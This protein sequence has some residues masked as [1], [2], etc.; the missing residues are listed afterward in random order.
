[1]L[2][3]YT[4]DAGAWGSAGAYASACVDMLRNWAVIANENDAKAA[5]KDKKKK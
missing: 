3:L 1:M 4:Q 5:A 2:T